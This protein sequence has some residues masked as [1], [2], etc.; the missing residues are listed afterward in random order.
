VFGFVGVMAVF[1]FAVDKGV[2][3]LLYDW[4]LGWK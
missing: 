4:V 2:E 1:L 3:K